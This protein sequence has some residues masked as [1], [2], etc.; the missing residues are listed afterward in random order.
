MT[1]PTSKSEI[2]A[3]IRELGRIARE[4]SKEQDREKLLDTLDEIRGISNYVL[5]K[6]TK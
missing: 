6:E 3:V 2:K 5:S 1:K 4:S